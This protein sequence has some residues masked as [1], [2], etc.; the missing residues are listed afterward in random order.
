[1]LDF[2][3]APYLAQNLAA[4]ATQGRLVQIATMGGG[5]ASL[6]L[7]LLM[8][9]RLRLTGTVLRARPLEEKALVTHR[10]AEQVVPLLAREIVRPV[11]DR[12]FDFADA[13][14]AHA[15]LESNTNFGKV[16]LHIRK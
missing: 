11:I 6:D 15:Y 16:L 5:E 1:V 10:F 7:G 4:L 2:V 13:A 3:G 8:R 12:V 9:K 14:T